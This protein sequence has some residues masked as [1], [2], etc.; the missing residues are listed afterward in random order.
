MYRKEYSKGRY[1]KEKED[2]EYKTHKTL[3]HKELARQAIRTYFKKTPIHLERRPTPNGYIKKTCEQ[4]TGEKQTIKPVLYIWRPTRCHHM[5]HTDYA[6]G[7]SSQQFDAKTDK[8]DKA[9]VVMPE[10][11]YN[12]RVTRDSVYAHEL[13]ETLAGSHSLAIKAERKVEK[14]YG[15]TRERMIRLAVKNFREAYACKQPIKK[16]KRVRY[17]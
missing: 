11:T 12:N 4:T 7:Y 10:S 1:I 15:T 2:P 16:E 17:Y 9:V 8:M 6:T 3:S 13:A 14:H 5:K